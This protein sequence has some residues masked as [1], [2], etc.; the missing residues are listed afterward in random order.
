MRKIKNE[1][2]DEKKI[3][4]L[5]IDI[6][7]EKGYKSKE[8]KILFKKDKDNFNQLLVEFEIK[9]SLKDQENNDKHIQDIKKIKTIEELRITLRELL[10]KFFASKSEEFED[11]K[12]KVKVNN[13]YFELLNKFNI[14]ENESKINCGFIHMIEKDCDIPNKKIKVLNRITNNNKKINKAEIDK[15]LELYPEENNEY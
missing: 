14:F 1:K 2:I 10:L 12:K 15:Y 11:F 6:L 3:I 5:I 7:I 13:E 9:K 4:N 8:E